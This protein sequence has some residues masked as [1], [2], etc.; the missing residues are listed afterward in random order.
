MP[1]RRCIGIDLEL[2]S[3]CGPAFI[4]EPTFIVMKRACAKGGVATGVSDHGLLNWSHPSRHAGQ[5][6]SSVGAE[7]VLAARAVVVDVVALWH[8]ARNEA[9]THP[10][11]EQ[12]QRSRQQPGEK[13]RSVCGAGQHVGPAV[14]A[15]QLYGVGSRLGHV[16]HG[17]PGRGGRRGPLSR[18][19][20]IARGSTYA[21]DTSG[22]RITGYS[23]RCTV[24]EVNSVV[25]GMVRRWRVSE[26]GR[27]R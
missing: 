4:L 17:H 21:V 24:L 27:R 10:A 22:R 18:C 19:R 11:P 15:S 5:S 9:A 13:S 7:V 23:P 25:G 16:H 1:S 8:A 20:R 3:M 14:G 26:S 6:K 12:H 2:Q